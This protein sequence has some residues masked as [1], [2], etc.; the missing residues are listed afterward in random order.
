MFQTELLSEVFVELADTLVDDFDLIDFLTTLSDGCAD[1]LGPAEAG[2]ILLDPQGHLQLMASTSE[3]MRLLELF[4]LQNDEGPCTD[5]IQT[6]NPITN[7]SVRGQGSPWPRFDA[8]ADNLGFKWVHA[9]PMR[10]RSETIGAIN[11][12]CAYDKR[13]DAT[14]IAVGRALAD[15]ASIGILQERSLR[16]ARFL[17]EQLQTAL[18]TR[19]AIEQAKGLL[20]ERLKIDVDAAFSLLRSHARSHN[21]HLGELARSLMDGSYDHEEFAAVVAPGVE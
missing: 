12:F 13:L 7:H 15:V 9:F 21:R 16:E 19:I 3:Q 8:A 1:L 18:N 5:V 17:N 11:V 4:E 6:N 10:V 20:A 14:A 2:V